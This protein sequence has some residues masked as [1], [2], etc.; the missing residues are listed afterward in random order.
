MVKKL[1]FWG[2]MI[3]FC[4]TLTEI[5]LQVV[6]FLMP[7]R[8]MSNIDPIISDPI[9]GHRPNPRNPDH[10]NQGFRNAQVP[11]GVDIVALGD[12][13]TYGT[14]VS[15]ENAWPQ[16]LAKMT[17]LKTYNMAYGGYCPVH[18]L[19]L[20][21]EATGLKP[22]MVIEA[23]YAGNDLY[24]A[25]TIV[26][27]KNNELNYLKTSDK[28][29]SKEIEKLQQGES[30]G[31]AVAKVD[32]NVAEEGKKSLLSSLKSFGH[33]HFK[34]YRVLSFTKKNVFGFSDDGEEKRWEI[35]QALA[36]SKYHNRAVPFECKSIK[37]ILTPAY[38]LG[39][40]NLDDPRIS[41]GLAICLKSIRIMQER[42]AAAG[43]DFCVLFIPTKELVFSGLAKDLNNLDY[44]KLISNEKQ[45]WEISRRF[46]QQNNIKYIDALP[47]LQGQLEEGHQAYAVNDDGHPKEYGQQAIAAAVAG[48]MRNN[49]SG[50]N[51]GVDQAGVVK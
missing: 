28:A 30:I 50:R 32:V 9:L 51:G 46:L 5:S 27:A 29:R 33:N 19:L 2:L 14:G 39:V 43:I 13:Q 6:D 22:K 44:A 25:F 16:Q 37:T 38:R 11:A 12:S 40:L 47:F 1:L 7:N 20:L 10:D 48:F 3:F 17:G 18:S 21:D 24:E 49:T 45:M 8:I 34:I 31:K 42:L 41:E 26:Y 4:L 36:N 35:Y 23:F 15:R